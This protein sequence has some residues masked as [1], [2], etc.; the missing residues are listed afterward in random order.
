MFAKIFE[1]LNYT[2][3]VISCI[4]L[5]GISYYYVSLEIQWSFVESKI[6]NGLLIFGALML[7]NFAIDTVTRQLTIE[8]SNRNAYHLLIYPLVILSFPVESVDL[9]YILGSAALWSAWRNTRLFI[10]S[11]NNNDKLKRLLDSV[12]LISASSLLILENLFFLL[13]PLLLL[14]TINIKQDIKYFIIITITPIIILPSAYIISFFLFP[15]EYLFSSYLLGDL[16]ISYEINGLE[17]LFSSGSLLLIILLFLYS[18]S[19]KL[20]RPSGFQRKILDI[21]GIIFLILI[22]VFFSLNDKISGSEF[23]YTSLI[24]VYFI[25]QI[26]SKKINVFYINFIFISIIISTIIFNYII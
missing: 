7:T 2:S 3:F 9:R 17:T 5:L 12:L 21:V 25:S 15:Q 11:N 23:H 24:L 19:I 14:F 6:L 4:L 10:E 26:F 16:S 20:F 22:I 13:V 1:K 18:A 8:R